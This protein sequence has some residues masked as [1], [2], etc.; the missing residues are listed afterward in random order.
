MG[1][2]PIAVP[3]SLAQVLNSAGDKSNVD[4]DYLLQTAIRES[5][6]NPEAKAPTSSAVGL[7]QFLES[8]WL[9]VMKE[10]GPRLGYQQYA[11]AITRDADGDYTIKNKALRK[12]ILALR[13]DPQIAADM[14]AAFTQSNGAYL[15][16][17]FGK[18]PSGGELYIAHFLGPQGAEKLLRAGL[19]NPDQIAAKLFP[20]Q[21]KANPS[22]FYAGGEARTIKD[23]YRALVAKHVG[24]SQPVT[25][26]D[27][28]KFTAQQMASS[29]AGRWETEALPSRFSKADMSFTSFFSTEAPR[30]VT[31]PL[32]ATDALQ[33]LVAPEISDPLLS[34]YAPVIE[35]KPL[36]LE[37]GFVPLPAPPPLLPPEQQQAGVDLMATAVEAVPDGAPKARVLMT[38]EPGSSAFLTQLYG[39]N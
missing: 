25:S 32:I 29:P 9:Q 38:R 7:F 12:E 21:A 10:Q 20:K 4:F 19:Q 33:S 26:I 6:L 22:I 18:M 5:S 37:L 28:A 8:T 39:Q 2:S 17:K 11:D 31:E 16:A 15:E 27:D 23:L 34:A 14:A 13:E 1:V 24:A 3:Q 30:A 36:D 35:A